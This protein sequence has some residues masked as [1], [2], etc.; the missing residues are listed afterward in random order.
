MV[1]RSDFPYLNTTRVEHLS[2]GME[3]NK[4][5]STCSFPGNASQLGM[6]VRHAHGILQDLVPVSM[7]KD[8][9]WQMGLLLFKIGNLLWQ[10]E[11][12]N[13]DIVELDK[14]IWIHDTVMLGCPD[15][16][17]LWKPK[18][19]Y[20]S[21]IPLEIIQWGPPRNYWCMAFEHENQLIKG[22]VTHSNF[23][24]PCL[25]AADRKALWVALQ[26]VEK[27]LLP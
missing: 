15:L 6:F 22:G 25:S 27:R 14:L 16:M 7:K 12:T 11:F 2:Q 17:H 4:V 18:N 3:G 8:P 21:H 23:A 26:E 10:R 13:S 9:V 1:C 24:N 19:H 5:S 20:L